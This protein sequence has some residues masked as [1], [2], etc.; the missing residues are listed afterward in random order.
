MT[1]GQNP[2]CFDPELRFLQIDLAP[3]TRVENI[4]LALKSHGQGFQKPEGHGY[5]AT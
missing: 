1:E 3:F 4:Q 2:E 5:H